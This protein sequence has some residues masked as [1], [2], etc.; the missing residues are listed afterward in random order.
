MLKLRLCT[1]KF[2]SFL[3]EAGSSEELEL[4][5]VVLTRAFAFAFAFAFDTDTDADALCISSGVRFRRNSS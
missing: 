3:G 5:S 4:S 1:V 2:L